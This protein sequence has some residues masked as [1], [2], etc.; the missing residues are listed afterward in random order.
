MSV[1]ILKQCS[2]FLFL[3]VFET[4]RFCLD[5]LLWF[6]GAEVESLDSLEIK[7]LLKPFK[8]NGRLLFI[9]LVVMLD[10][11]ASCLAI[12]LCFD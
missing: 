9:G 10:T 2:T 12:Y 6:E 8:A 3:I 4:L 7:V 1:F 5:C 11:C